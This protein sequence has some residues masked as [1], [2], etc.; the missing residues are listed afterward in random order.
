MYR[1]YRISSMSQSSVIVAN[2]LAFGRTNLSILQENHLI[3]FLR[4]DNEKAQ[5]CEAEQFILEEEVVLIH[6]L[7][8]GKKFIDDRKWNFVLFVISAGVKKFFGG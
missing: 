3:S 4:Y 6:V 2:P 5:L 7:P 8:A 1:I